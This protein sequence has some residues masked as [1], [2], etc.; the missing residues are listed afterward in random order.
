[1]QELQHKIFEHDV[2]VL[3]PTLKGYMKA[4]PFCCVEECAAIDGSS[5]M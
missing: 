4:H 5:E 2:R 1:V 3:Q